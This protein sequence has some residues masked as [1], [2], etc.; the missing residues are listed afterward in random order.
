MQPVGRVGELD[1]GEQPED[2]RADVALDRGPGHRRPRAGSWTALRDTLRFKR[3]FLSKVPGRVRNASDK[4][5]E[6]QAVAL[7]DFGS[8]RSIAG[9]FRKRSS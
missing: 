7:L 1:P 9:R 4:I 3:R 6:V 2:G 5:R 8:S